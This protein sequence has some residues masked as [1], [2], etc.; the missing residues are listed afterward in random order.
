MATDPSG[1]DKAMPIV[2]AHMAK[3]ERAVDRSRSTHAGRPYAVVRQAL[4]EA[5]RDEDAHELYRRS[6]M[7]WH[8]RFLRIPRPRP[9][10]HA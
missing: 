9:D 5:L 2:A 7:S 6:S 8:G 10:I 3:I 1:Y 4:V